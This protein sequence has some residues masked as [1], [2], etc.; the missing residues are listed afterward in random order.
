MPRGIL[1]LVVAVELAVFMGS[2]IAWS[3]AL[4]RK[5]RGQPFYPY[6]SRRPVPW[7]LSDLALLAFV[8][9]TATV[10][11]ST[12][13]RSFLATGA[14]ATLT[15][16]KS[17]TFALLILADSTV[18]LTV[19]G[20][21]ILFLSWR[22]GAGLHDFGVEPAKVDSDVGLGMMAFV[23]LAVPV[24]MI[25]IWLMWLLP[26]Q[27]QHPLVEMLK[28]DGSPQLLLV[29]IFV[30]VI[31]APIVEE[32]FFRVLLQ[33]WLENVACQ[34]KSLHGLLFGG[35]EPSKLATAPAENFGV[36]AGSSPEGIR[37]HA[38]EDG[39]PDEP[40]LSGHRKAT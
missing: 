36:S 13:A 31:V 12:I 27:D 20:A 16:M 17:H 1:I 32:Y 19:I 35:N 22:V 10:I 11:V 23:M 34:S 39:P 9:L 3:F 18:S 21:A 28:E 37:N 8:A 40:V 7:G 4:A 24:L 2:M 33:G 25:Q 5:S 30:A 38:A 6:E 15:D 14:D 26:K 29:S